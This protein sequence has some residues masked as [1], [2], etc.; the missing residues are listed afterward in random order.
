MAMEYEAAAE[1]FEHNNIHEKC[2]GCTALPCNMYALQEKGVN[3][4][5]VH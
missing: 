1:Y 2:L 4:N 3:R 5:F